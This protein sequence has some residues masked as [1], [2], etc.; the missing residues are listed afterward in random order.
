MAALPGV[1][2]AA[3]LGEGLVDELEEL[4]AVDDFN[5]GRG[6]GA[7]GHDPD[8]GRVLNTDALAERVVGFDLGGSLPMGS[9]AKGR[10]TPWLA[11]ISQ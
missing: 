4:A 3:R 1:A 10:A 9:M 2:L 6:V 7:V 5:E 11:R 8:G